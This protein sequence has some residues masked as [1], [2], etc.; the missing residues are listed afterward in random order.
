MPQGPVDRVAVA[1][2]WRQMA[3]WKGG[4][5]GVRGVKFPGNGIAHP[6]E[7]EGHCFWV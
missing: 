1:D 2:T 6:S 4:G 3:P 7:P 5:F